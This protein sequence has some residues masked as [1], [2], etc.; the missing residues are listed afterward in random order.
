MTATN[1]VRVVHLVDTNDVEGVR[2]VAAFPWDAGGVGLW[3][4]TVDPL[5]ELWTTTGQCEWIPSRFEALPRFAGDP[6]IRWSE[7][8]AITWEV[9]EESLL[10]RVEGAVESLL[11][12]R[13]WSDS[14]AHLGALA[15]MRGVPTYQALND[16]SL[17]DY[18]VDSQGV[19]QLTPWAEPSRDACLDAPLPAE[20][21]AEALSE[22]LMTV[23]ADNPA[24]AEEF[25]EPMLVC[26]PGTPSAILDRLVLDAKGSLRSLI[27]HCA[28]VPVDVRAR[29]GGVPESPAEA[30][31]FEPLSGRTLAGPILDRQRH[32]GAAD[33]ESVKALWRELESALEDA[34][35]SVN[36]SHAWAHGHIPDYDD[37]L[38]APA[39]SRAAIAELVM[40]NWAAV[41]AREVSAGRLLLDEQ[42]TEVIE[43]ALQA[44]ATLVGPDT[45]PL[46]D[47]LITNK[48]SIDSWGALEEPAQEDD[49]EGGLQGLRLGDAIL[50]SVLADDSG[51]VDALMQFGTQL[52]WETEAILGTQ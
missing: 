9:N 38:L 16:E 48:L 44:L 4:T 30:V 2:L 23:R 7:P 8:R 5:P 39:N 32:S 52:G 22:L 49:H 28:L 45:R 42:T 15:I 13:D 47:I 20:L 1:R 14:V 19:V 46:V 21:T 24:F 6:P 10:D 18:E 3:D 40:R 29:V 34:R 43:S 41:S 51:A 12:E 35:A 33:S 25:V 37:E 11:F 17:Q 27:A 50:R 31:V 36:I 26:Y